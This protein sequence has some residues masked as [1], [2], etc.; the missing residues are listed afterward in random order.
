MRPALAGRAAARAARAARAR[1]VPPPPAT[2]AARGGAGRIRSCQAPVRAGGRLRPPCKP[3]DATAGHAQGR[4]QSRPTDWSR[5]PRVRNRDRQFRAGTRTAEHG[6]GG[7]AESLLLAARDWDAAALPA[8]SH[9]KHVHTHQALPRGS[10]VCPPRVARGRARGA[11]GS[12]SAAGRLALPDCRCELAL[13]WSPCFL[14][15]PCPLLQTCSRSTRV[16][17]A[18]GLALGWRIAFVSAARVQYSPREAQPRPLVERLRYPW[19]GPT[20]PLPPRPRRARANAR[21]PESPPRQP[22]RGGPGPPATRPGSERVLPVW[23]P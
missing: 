5:R 11:T 18:L 20:T 6:R 19:D 7:A 2:V 16:A 3:G 14:S 13:L 1:R 22:G 4:R 17:K 23:R 9:L 10:H 12:G 8:T 21:L 15:R